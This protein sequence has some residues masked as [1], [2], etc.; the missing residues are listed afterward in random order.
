MTAAVAVVVLVLASPRHVGSQTYGDIVGR[1]R[2]SWG[3]GVGLGGARVEV[4]GTPLRA[5][6]DYKGRYRIHAV[7]VGRHAVLVQA[8]GY[9][10]ARQEDVPV[11]AG[12]ETR[13]DVFLPRDT[14]PGGPRVPS[15]VVDPHGWDI[16]A[17]LDALDLAALPV[18][19]LLEAA[20]LWNG[21]QGGSYAAGRPGS[22]QFTIDGSVVRSP[23]D[24]STAPLGLRVPAGILE[25][26]ALTDDPWIG[27]VGL[28]G[29]QRLTT[30]EGGGE[31]RGRVGFQTDRP[32]SG[33][34]DIGFDRLLGR[35]EGPI[36]RA[37]VVG[38]LDATGRFQAEPLSAPRGD[39]RTPAP[40]EL[41]HAAGERVDGAMNL[42]TPL[43]P[44]Y[45][46]RALAVQSLEQRSLFDPAFKYDPG[47]GAGRR[48]AATLVAAEV[49]HASPR[50]T[51]FL[52]A[53]YFARTLTESDLAAVPSYAAGAL[54]GSYDFL[55]MDVA[56]AQDTAAARTP[57]PGFVR[58][59]FSEITPWGVAAFF[60]SGGS[61]GSLL[62]NRYREMR[63]D[64]AVT[65][66]PTQSFMVSG[67]AGVAVG[68][69][70]AF[71][72][73]FASLP[74]G[75]SVPPATAARLSPLWLTVGSRAHGQLAGGS[76]V[77]SLRLD[78]VSLGVAAAK[79]MRASI[80]PR[81]GV[82][83]PV[84][85][86]LVSATAAR[87]SQF[88]DLQFLSNATFADSLAGGRFR[89]GDPDLGYESVALVELRFGLRVKHDATVHAVVYKRRF[90]DLVASTPAAIADSSVFG[91]RDRLDVTGVEVVLEKGLGA[92]TRVT[93]SYAAED[94]SFEAANGFWV[95]TG[96]PLPKN[97]FLSRFVLAARG[98]A[99]GGV[100]AGGVMRVRSG[101]PF[102]AIP[103][104]RRRTDVTVDALLRHAVRARGLNGWVYLDGRNLLN[105]RSLVAVPGPD[106]AA[107]DNLAQAAYA[108]NPGSI[109]YDSP[110]YREFADLDGNGVIEGS[111]EL[112]ALFRA[113]AADFTQPL[114]AYGPLRSVRV[115]IEIVF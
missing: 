68:R 104:D 110:R 77:G 99:P 3:R 69:V 84:G 29:V 31:W 111:G 95:A 14:M 105:T 15:P 48:I 30:V 27:P 92:T 16:A 21:A 6:T 61:R 18:T 108:A 11:R 97:D 33:P 106:S 67:D 65:T 7:P 12:V 34:A 19:D 49:R 63:L 91:N 86:A 115:G 114:R 28:S 22:Q 88:P 89:R 13:Q 8:V 87:L 71:Q 100:Q 76:L 94:A 57:I 43:G 9:A 36:G 41:G 56:E 1:V 98:V 78:V 26:A 42:S 25:E 75:D 32:F 113:A 5:V 85:N 2:E 38:I 10:S 4:V 55:G 50:V 81:L 59:D 47:P 83:V 66:A 109:P 70:R 96:I 45:T 72:R 51:T 79:G 74:V 35:F 44:S 62:W 53:R 58:P 23:Y 93:A 80:S 60:L 46:L 82:A 40:W 54:G 37:R 112:L 102:N 107:L 17:R 24:G 90:D 64:V 101:A 103:S 39:P 20:G 52:R 73:A